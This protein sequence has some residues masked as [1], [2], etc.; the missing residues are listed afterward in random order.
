M[1]SAWSLPSAVPPC[2]REQ[3]NRKN[4]HIPRGPEKWYQRERNG[5]PIGGGVGRRQHPGLLLLLV[6]DVLRE[7]RKVHARQ[8][9]GSEMS[10]DIHDLLYRHPLP[11]KVLKGQG[12][13]SGILEVKYFHLMLE[14]QTLAL[15]GTCCALHT[16]LECVYTVDL[17]GALSR[18]LSSAEH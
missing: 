6:R 9:E 5:C 18:G 13:V 1:N 4:K 8:L 11:D 7:P 10:L 14:R 17:P 16:L 15:V 3:T 12:D 2:C